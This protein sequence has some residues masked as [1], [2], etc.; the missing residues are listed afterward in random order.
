MS[1]NK[2]QFNVTEIKGSDNI[3]RR[4]TP[5]GHLFPA[6]PAEKVAGDF[7]PFPVLPENVYHPAGRL[8]V[9]FD[10]RDGPRPFPE[11]S[12]PGGTGPAGNVLTDIKKLRVPK[13]AE[14]MNR[15][16]LVRSP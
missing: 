13:N 11:Q 1:K 5:Y 10:S 4:Q 2:D 12:G 6:G 14:L 16:D 8:G 3:R 9:V 7:T 15:G